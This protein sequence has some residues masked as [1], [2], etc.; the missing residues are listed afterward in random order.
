MRRKLANLGLLGWGFLASGTVGAVTTGDPVCDLTKETRTS[1]EC[2]VT[3]SASGSDVDILFQIPTSANSV[4]TGTIEPFLTTQ[5]GAKGSDP[6]D[7]KQQESGFNTDTPVQNVKDASGTL[8]DIKRTGQNGDVG[9]TNSLQLGDIPIVKVGDVLYREILFDF[10][11][12]SKNPWLSLDVIRIF[13]GDGFGDK[14]N[15]Y[16]IVPT[17]HDWQGF[18]NEDAGNPLALIWSLDTETAN[19]SILLDYR[20]CSGQ[21]AE[22]DCKSGS[23]QGFDIRMLLPNSLFAGWTSQDYFVLY[24]SFGWYGCDQVPDP[25]AQSTAP[26]GRGPR[27]QA[28]PPQT[29]DRCFYTNDGFEE[30]S[31]RLGGECVDGNCQQVPEPGSIALFGLGLLGLGAVRRRRALAS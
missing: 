13:M 15:L 27:S 28:A 5:A 18:V 7:T 22:F 25:S 14:A 19:R 2:T 26:R 11:Q 9:F 17:G 4:G 10:N 16:D 21:N 31:V 1:L 23:G 30:W 20:L 24:T 8:L 12:T 3:G 29:I 6:D